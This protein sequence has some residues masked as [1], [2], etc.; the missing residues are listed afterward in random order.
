MTDIPVHSAQSRWQWERW[1]QAVVGPGWT[2]RARIGYG[3]DV[4]VDAFDGRLLGVLLA[5]DTFEVRER[6]D[7]FVSLFHGEFRDGAVVHVD[8][9]VAIRIARWAIGLHESLHREHNRRDISAWQRELAALRAEL[10]G[11]PQPDAPAPQQVDDATRRLAEVAI[12][13][14]APLALGDVRPDGRI[15][16]DTRFTPANVADFRTLRGAIT[17]DTGAFEVR[18]GLHPGTYA[19]E[20]ARVVA[21]LVDEARDT[22]VGAAPFHAERG[23]RGVARIP[24]A[25]GRSL[26]R[27][28][29]WVIGAGADLPDRMERAT[30]VAAEAARRSARATRFGLDDVAAQL[31]EVSLSR[32]ATIGVVPTLHEIPTALR[33]PY[34][35]EI[36]ELP[37]LAAAVE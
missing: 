30:T 16:V 4:Y 9:D 6:N 25:P 2:I 24:I 12:A 20:V 32:W 5:N 29:M 19:P 23:D 28:S 37:E 1:A 8:D 17:A 14:G 26:E 36:A 18:V 13:A 31:L 11:A 15:R 7:A 3:I 34:A 27:L 10:C 35:G 21:C 22:V 33:T